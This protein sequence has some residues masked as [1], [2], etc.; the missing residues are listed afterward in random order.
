MKQRVSR[1]TDN[2]GHSPEK[3]RQ[4]LLSSKEYKDTISILKPMI[5]TIKKSECARKVLATCANSTKFQ[6][7]TQQKRALFLK[8]SLNLN[9][10]NETETMQEALFYLGFFEVMVTT[11]VD[12]LIMIFIASHHDFYVYYNRGYAKNFEDLDYATL[13]EKLAFLKNHDFNFPVVNKKLRNGIA[14]MDFDPLPNGKIKIGQE[15]YDLKKELFIVSAFTLMI[16]S[17][18]R[19]VQFPELL[20]D[21]GQSS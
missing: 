9:P 1:L 3:I 5:E 11:V 8:K 17:A 10:K 18:L 6:G 2:A 14:H 19:D 13:A 15:E 4:N 7:A 20:L 12:Q 21:I 16:S